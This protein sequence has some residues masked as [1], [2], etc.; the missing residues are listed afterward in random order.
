MAHYVASKGGVIGLTKALAL[1]LAPTASRS[2]HPA[3]HDRHAD[4][5]PRRGARRHREARQDRRP[6]DSRRRAGTPEEIAATCGFLC[7]DEAAS[8]PA[9]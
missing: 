4:A 8:S 3:G 2:T 7:S 6:G 9:R 5:A 1:E